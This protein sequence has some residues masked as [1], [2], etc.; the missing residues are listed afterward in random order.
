MLGDLHTAFKH[1]L[2]AAE[3]IKEAGGVN[4]LG[5]SKFIRYLLYH[6]LQ[7]NRLLSWDPLMHCSSSFMKPHLALPLIRGG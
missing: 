7:G 6:C 4:A 2:G 3:I 1:I 5:L